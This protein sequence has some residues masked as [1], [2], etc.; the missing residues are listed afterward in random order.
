[1]PIAVLVAALLLQAP[2][3]PAHVAASLSADRIAV[4]ATTTLRIEVEARGTTSPDIGT[5]V[6]PPGLELVGSSDFSQLRLSAPGRSIRSSRREYMVRAAAPGVYTIPSVQVAIGAQR[7]RTESLELTVTG[8]AAPRGG[9][10]DDR[11]DVSAT[12]LRLSAAPDTV[13][14]GQQ[15]I[16]TAEA[17]FAEE[18][19]FRQTR[20]AS[21][22][23]PASSGFWV[24][25]LPD[26][27]TVSLRV[28]DGRSVETQTYRRAYF[29]LRPGAFW[30]PPAYLHY[31]LRRG[32][33]QPPENRR[34]A[35]DSLRL[36]VLPLPA[37]GRPASFTGAVGRMDL[38]ASVSPARVT[39]GEAAVLTVEL[40]G[41]GNIR[42]LPEPALPPLDGMERFD[43]VQDATVDVVDDVVGGTKRFRWTLVP[44]RPRTFVI[45]PIEYSYFDPELRSYVTLRSDSL[46]VHAV[47][48]VAGQPEDTVIRPIR[49]QPGA[50]PAAWAVT[51]WFAA[52]QLLP[53][54]LVGMAGAVIR[55]RQRP[56]GPTQHARR[57]RRELA[58]LHGEPP[59]QALARADRLL[60]QAVLQVAQA[61]GDD[62]VA[63]L[64]SAGRPDA[65]ALLAG[66][67]AELRRARYAPD[68][69]I[70]ADALLRRADAFV[71][72]LRRRRGRN[73]AG[74]GPAG[75]AAAALL[76]GAGLAAALLGGAAGAADAEDQARALFAAAVT[77]HD[78][79][80]VVSAANRFHDYAR[81]R[82]GD[83]VG[84]Y[85]LGVAAWR[86]GDPG[87]AVWAWLRA[88]LLAP[89]DAD[90]RHNLQ[91][92]GADAAARAVLPRDRLATGERAALA[93]LA[94]WV[95]VL[96]SGHAVFRRQRRAWAVAA[97]AAA[98]LLVLGTLAAARAAA[99]V[100]VAPLGQ[101]S[102]AWAG[103][104]I[105]D[106][107]V[108]EL[109]PGDIARLVER[110]DPWLLVRLGDGRLAWVERGG[111]AAP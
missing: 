110:R 32:F 78:A 76:A 5:P 12:T 74:R 6:L 53:L 72:G 87:R 40:R 89:R 94:W 23:P 66:L 26:P 73:D 88:G 69:D 14:V 10:F 98:A 24:Q 55:R 28:R 13:Y 50:A 52:A 29:P 79:G 21:F 100:H 38:A 86:A 108:A 90:S 80:D 84:W 111:V 25:D 19:R 92:A 15:L 47:P 45:P 105:H 49:L 61:P 46:V 16:L 83:P 57:L 68:A 34:V 75:A 101:G 67:V 91:L 102:A 39:L 11:G 30:I 56:P 59:E 8:A 93:A 27:I 35:S 65:A 71:D 48:V 107:Q 77:S 51:P 85:N 1:M 60:H 70:D 37:A 63:A 3:E 62:P 43:A 4:G 20:P 81:L 7:F 9:F 54:L 42:A 64:R 109:A 18:A 104:S 103:P 31:E 106:R 22:E 97:P 2:Q 58:A 36:V 99:P 95:L 41:R 82:P 44:E 33:L 17:T 96:A